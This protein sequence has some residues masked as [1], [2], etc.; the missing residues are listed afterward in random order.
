MAGHDLFETR[1]ADA[2]GRYLREAPVE[3]DAAELARSIARAHPR[4]R[5]AGRMD[6]HRR[7]S[8]L[9]WLV[10][11]VALLAT[12]AAGAVMVGSRLAPAVDVAPTAAPLP[13]TPA[14]LPA[15][16]FTVADLAGT[17]TGEVLMPGFV[18]PEASITPAKD[19]TF[20]TSVTIGA[21]APGATCGSVSYATRD[22]TGS[23]KPLSCSGSLK[24]RGPYEGGSGFAFEEAISS[25][26]GAPVGPEQAQACS[27]N[28]LVLTPLASGATVGV[29]E[30]EGGMA[31]QDYGV[32]AKS[33]TP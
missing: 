3:V 7:A 30:R 24:Y 16:G 31:W 15:A 19:T 25:R 21:C 11:A 4:S 18:S 22:W 8:R 33:A 20:T 10:V 27:N 17:W 2:Y 29:E 14:L 12:L 9:A 6:G 1:F 32:L 13:S 5:V 28:I 26:S 23:G